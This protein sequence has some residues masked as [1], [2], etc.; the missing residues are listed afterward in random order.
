MYFVTISILLIRVEIQ[1]SM[2]IPSILM[3]IF[4]MFMTISQGDLVIT[5]VLMRLQ[6]V[7]IFAKALS[8]S[9]FCFLRDNLSVIISR[10]D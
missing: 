2:I 8:T 10:E 7:D 5:Y 1:W 6:V 4:I 3:L 9:Q